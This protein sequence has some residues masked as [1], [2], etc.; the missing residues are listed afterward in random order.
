MWKVILFNGDFFISFPFRIIMCMYLFISLS[1]ATIISVSN[2]ALI[3]MAC[4]YRWKKKNRL[5][6]NEETVDVILLERKLQMILYRPN[7]R[8]RPQRGKHFYEINTSYKKKVMLTS[9]NSKF[10]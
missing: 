4:L 3:L 7:Y 10:Y 8:P 2:M 5:L 9:N 1:I 6:S